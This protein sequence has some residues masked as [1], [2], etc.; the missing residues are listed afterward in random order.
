MSD[1]KAA[2]P[3]HGSSAAIELMRCKACETLH[4]FPRPFCPAC[5]SGDVQKVAARGTGTLAAITTLHR[6]P[7]KEHKE[8][9]P[10][11]IALVDLDEGV[12]VMGAADRE[13]APGDTVLAE[14]GEGD[15]PIRFRRR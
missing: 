9:L 6:A 3:D 5:G 15:A 1:P 11:A 7:T 13:L 8:R 2:N 4:A 14:L 12:R 10:Y